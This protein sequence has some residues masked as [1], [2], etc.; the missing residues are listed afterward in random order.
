MTEVL[1]VCTHVNGT[2]QA[3]HMDFAVL[4]QEGCCLLEFRF[5]GPAE[6]TCRH[7]NST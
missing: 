1:D 6:D 5:E 2:I 4:E 7:A 3:I